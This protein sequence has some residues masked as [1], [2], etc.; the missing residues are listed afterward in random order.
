MNGR[1]AGGERRP[2]VG[3]NK[4]LGRRR[5]SQNCDVT[6]AVWL[7]RAD[8]RVQAILPQSEVTACFTDICTANIDFELKLDRTL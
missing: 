7:T 3:R 2:A 6:P 1:A 5:A 4:G 8:G